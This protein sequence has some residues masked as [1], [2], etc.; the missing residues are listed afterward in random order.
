MKDVEKKDNKDKLKADIAE[1]ADEDFDRKRSSPKQ[2]KT[3][4]R[5]TLKQNVS[6]GVLLLPI[7]C[8]P[9]RM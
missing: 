5:K 8:F 6:T 4:S 9:C 1:Q 7:F 2:G 3:K